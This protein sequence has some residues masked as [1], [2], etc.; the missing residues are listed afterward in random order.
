MDQ[1]M[2]EVE[3]GP[4]IVTTKRGDPPFPNNP[5]ILSR[6]AVATL[7]EPHVGAVDE[8][9][10][11]L[12]RHGVRQQGAEWGRIILR[13]KSGDLAPVML[14]DGTVEVEATTWLRLATDAGF[15]A[16][17]LATWARLAEKGDA[18]VRQ[19]ILDAYNA[20]RAP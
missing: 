8:V 10:R 12:L 20:R 2:Q 6:C 15:E 9:A 14:P 13:L 1:T 16:V 18:R 7:D 5:A 19:R 3:R 11:I 17:E 4:Y